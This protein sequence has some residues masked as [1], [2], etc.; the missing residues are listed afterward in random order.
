MLRIPAGL[1]FAAQHAYDW[2]NNESNNDTGDGIWY[3]LFRGGAIGGLYRLARLMGLFVFIVFAL[4]ICIRMLLHTGDSSTKREFK[5]YWARWFMCL[6]T[7]LLVDM[8]AGV[9]LRLGGAL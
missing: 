1:L 8:I 3:K 6:V 4:M 2:L 7:F 9:A 5:S